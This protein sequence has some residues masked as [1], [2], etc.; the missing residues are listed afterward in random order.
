LQDLLI[1]S[2]SYHF[3]NTGMFQQ[4][5]INMPRSFDIHMHWQNHWHWELQTKCVA[6]A[7]QPKIPMKTPAKT[8]MKTPKAYG[9]TPKSA[10]ERPTVR[11]ER[12]RVPFQFLREEGHTYRPLDRP[13][14][15]L[16]EVNRS[17]SRERVQGRP[18]DRPTVGIEGNPVSQPSQRSWFS[19]TWERERPERELFERDRPRPRSR[20]IKI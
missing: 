14:E 1:F 11:P 13:G 16:F 18:L 2:T 3:E 9:P 6:L 12:P 4:T 20:R 7:I 17:R 10:S 5:Y 15:R 8:P 19:E